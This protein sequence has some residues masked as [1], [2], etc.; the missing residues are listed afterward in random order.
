METTITGIVYQD[1]LQQFVISQL[2]EDDKEGSIHFQ[3]SPHYLAEVCENLSTCFS[4]RL[5]VEQ[6]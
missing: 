3:H 5:I 2:D 6:S 1:M 4:G